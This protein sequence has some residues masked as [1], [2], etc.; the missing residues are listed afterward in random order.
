MSILSL[1]A[2]FQG[3]WRII[4]SVLDILII[5]FVIYFS[6]KVIRTNTRTTQIF[7]GIF[8]VILVDIL[9]KIIGLNTIQFI[10]DMFINWGF[11]AIIIIFQPEIRSLLEKLGKST[12]FSTFSTM[13]NDDKSEVVEA[14][15]TATTLLSKDQTGALITLG[16]SANLENYINT[17]TKL[18]AKVSAELLTSIFVTSTPLHD[19]AVIIQGDRVVCASAYFPPTN[20]MVSSRYGSRHR[21]AIGIS[22]VTDAITIVISEETGSISVTRGGNIETVNPA[23]LRRLL[24]NIIFNQNSSESSTVK[25]NSFSTKDSLNHGE[26]VDAVEIHDGQQEIYEHHEQENLDQVAKSAGMKLPHKKVRSKASYP[27]RQKPTLSQE[28]VER[29]RERAIQELDK[30]NKGGKEDEQR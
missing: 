2:S 29:L 17:G 15:V 18:E 22:E 13:S 10:A 30:N 8:F 11:L 7:K 1:A 21:A 25:M 19:G 6:L 27:E 20:R 23:E 14:I 26:L 3:V 28:E 24:K 4:G 9:A 5:W 12:F 16:Q